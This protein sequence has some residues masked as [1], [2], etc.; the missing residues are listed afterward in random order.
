ME[1]KPFI[2]DN[3]LVL[4]EE[5]TVSEL[6]GKLKQFEKRT[7]LIFRNKKYLGIIEKKKLLKSRIDTS[8]A[9]LKKFIQKTP[10][11]SE[12][13]D[14]VET[15]YLMYQ[16]NLDYIPVESDKEI[17]GVINASDLLNLAKNLEELKKTLVEDVKLVKPK[18]MNKDDPI[19]AAMA[20]MYN[21]KIDHVPLYDQ[22]KLY[23]IIT[24]KDILRGYLSWSP[25]RDVS[26][27]FNAQVSSTQGELP[28]IDH[29]PVENFS[30]TDNL[31]TVS[32]K[33]SLITALATMSTKGISDLLV[34]E[35]NEFLGLLTTKSLLKK[36]GGT[37][38]QKNFSI[39]FVGL[40]KVRLQSYQKYN[41]QKIA[42]NEAMKLQRKLKN[43]MNLTI[44]LKSYDKQGGEQ[45]FSVNLRI[46]F[47]SRVITSS[48]E[49]WDLE[50]ALRKTFN[51]A[52]NTVDKKFKN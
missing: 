52:K 19:S 31:E 9:R 4:E 45:K 50:T 18:K 44:H 51:N 12:H 41:I 8:E 5:A 6:I 43:D 20:I 10:I 17:I 32:S 34:M 42:S 14:L 2:T 3:Y 49:D 1:I 35:G 11:L 22:G 38:V 48:Q 36:I 25:K 27:K 24:F 40:N 21:D 15:A 29:L 13:A 30:T 23:G 37:K 26:A 28:K 16:N 33:E 47:P 39:K 46:D 7:A